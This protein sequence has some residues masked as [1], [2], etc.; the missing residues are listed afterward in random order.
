MCKHKPI[1][2]VTTGLTVIGGINWGLVGLG[3]LLGQNLNVVNLLV[4]K[5]PMAETV[6]YLAVGVS[7]LLVGFY[8][9]K[10]G[11]QCCGSG[12]C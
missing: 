5:W 11:D 10:G 3:S 9:V 2:A 1:C 7:A 8:A 4:G 12:T 6:V